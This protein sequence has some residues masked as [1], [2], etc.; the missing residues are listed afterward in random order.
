MLALMENELIPSGAESPSSPTGGSTESGVDLTDRG[1]A[2]VV[3]GDRTDIWRSTMDGHA[4]QNHLG[5]SALFRTAHEG[6]PIRIQPKRFTREH[7]EGL[8]AQTLA[9]GATLAGGAGERLRVEEP[10]EFRTCFEK[11]RD[12]ILHASAFRRLAG[13]TQVFIQPEDHQRTRLTH[14][15]EV[16]Q[17]AV[18]IASA[19][20]CNVA[21]TEAIALGHDC[22]HG[23]GG[24]ASEDAFTPY[25]P[26]GYDHATFGADVVLASLNLCAETSDGIRNHSWSRPI[27]STPE[28]EIVS[29]ADRIAYVCHDMED[30]SHV[31]I[32]SETM[33]PA[34]VAERCGLTRSDQLG[35]FIAAM[36]ETVSETGCIGMSEAQAEALA[37]FRAFNY[38][39]IYMRP[40]SLKQ[41]RAVI[42]ILGALVEFY[43]DRPHAISYG[44]HTM[45]MNPPTATSDRLNPEDQVDP[46]STEAFVRAV[47][48]VGGMTDKF[49]F[50]QAQSLLGWD[51]VSLPKTC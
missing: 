21:L 15:L 9:A 17:V 51:P 2:L 38:E 28:G 10:D 32:V 24:H 20:G 40:A 46:G 47:T 13:K 14:A 7:R 3:S 41:S 27:A 30:A 36:V 19:V 16:S 48:W 4:P 22:G 39:H 45:S 18:A 12:R 50:R 37:S 1:P 8:E 11:D 43:A 44:P 26:G 42:R 34:L 23:P 6:G 31:G 5:T 29:W 33:L 25:I 49:A 35:S